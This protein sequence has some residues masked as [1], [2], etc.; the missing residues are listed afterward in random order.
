MDRGKSVQDRSCLACHG[1]Q[2][3]G[4]IGNAIAR[5]TVVLGDLSSHMAVIAD[6]VSGTAMEAFGGQLNDVEPAAVLTYERNALGNFT[7]DVVQ[8]GDVAGMK[9]G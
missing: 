9:N 3:E 5:S 8:P 6:G 2:G 7:D 1:A 4:G